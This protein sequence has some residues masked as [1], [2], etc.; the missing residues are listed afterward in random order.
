M[1]L[2]RDGRLFASVALAL[3]VLPETVAG[4]LAPATPG[5]SSAVTLALVAVTIVIGFIAQ[6]S[7]NRLAIGP[8]TTVGQAIG[9]GLARMPALL[10]AFVLLIV[11]LFIVLVPLVLVF[12]AT[13]LIDSP[14]AGHEAPASLLLL[15]VIIAALCY[16]VFQLTVPLA[17]AEHGGSLHL[18][19]RSW[20]LA[21]GA[22]LRLLAFVAL[23]FFCL[24]VIVIAGEFALGSV[25]ALAFGPPDAFSLSALLIAL[26]VALLQAVFTVFFAVMLARIYV[27]LAGGAGAQP[28][29]PRSGT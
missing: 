19:V 23:V 29:V 8:S 22:Y 25:I 12:G 21:R 18:L 24:L 14:A 11:G 13:G 17:A 10:G 15:I 20:Q 7:L 26:I 3:V 5:G 1:V 6:V 27:Q 28:S 16:A 4:V 9:R 2:A